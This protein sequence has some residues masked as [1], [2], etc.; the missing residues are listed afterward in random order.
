MKPR[1]VQTTLSLALATATLGGCSGGLDR[2]QTA[3]PN[4]SAFREGL[5]PSVR[6]SDKLVVVDPTVDYG[7]ALRSA[8]LKLTGNYPTLDEIKKVR[9]AS[10]Q[11]AAYAAQID[12]Y[13]GR[14]AF[15]VQ[16][17]AF[18]RDTFKMGGNLAIGATNVNLDFAPTFAAMLVVQEKP[19][20][21]VLTA[22]SGTCPT[23]NAGTNTFTPGDCAN[24]PAVGVLNDQ[25]VQAQFFSSMA[26]RRTRW[27]QETFACNKF[28]AE[29][30]GSAQ[31]FPGGSFSSPWAMNT[32]SGKNNK[33]DA[34]IDFHDT[35]AI[36]CANC[37]T[38]MNHIAPLFGKFT[39][40]GLASGKIEVVTPV[41][42]NPF[43]DPSDWLPAGEGL[44]WRFGKPVANLQDLGA[45]VVADPDLAKCVSTRMW[46]WAMSRGDVVNDGTTLTATLSS[47]LSQSLTS[48][49][50]NVK[51]LIR[52]IFT[53]SS[54]VRY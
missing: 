34:K 47:Q 22:S 31:K 48:S 10:D 20:T 39:A 23:F 24:K 9:D 35:S 42:N 37:H 54:F 45:A 49:N 13:I 7:L 18:W 46:N 2:G 8:A 28:P 33:P 21:D 1:L 44:A 30:G 17:I 38:T 15:S 32:I 19:F 50:W 11:P 43:T 52:E 16:Q 36:I 51:K 5:P 53:N 41:P 40:T 4:S 25:G 26:F 29:T 6:D 12:D 14:S 3:D 27:L